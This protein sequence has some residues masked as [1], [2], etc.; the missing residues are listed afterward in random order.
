[1]DR[2]SPPPASRLV[3][4]DAARAFAALLVLVDH[5]CDPLS[6]T[7][8]RLSRDWFNPGVF[9]VILF[10]LVS[11][12]IIPVSL[13]RSGSLWR[14]WV[15]RVFRLYPLYLSCLVLLLVTWLL[16]LRIL[17]RELVD[18]APWSW[19]ANA[20][21]ATE[22]LRFQYADG[23]FWTLTYEMLFYIV[24]SLLFVLGLMRRTL[25][26]C[27]L[28]VL[29][30]V[31]RDVALP[32]LQHQPGL[33]ARSFWML[34]FFVGTLFHRLDAGHVSGRAFAG[35]I[36]TLG[37]SLC[38]TAWVNGRERMTTALGEIA[39]LACVSAWVAGYACFVVLLRTPARWIPR[40]LSRLGEVSYSIYLLQDHLMAPVVSFGLG[41]IGGA[42][43]T[44][45]TL[46]LSFVTYRWIEKPGIALGRGLVAWLSGSPERRPTGTQAEA[47]FAV[48]RKS[49]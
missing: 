36:T 46:G 10:F 30:L 8:Y 20:T 29:V 22:V 41:W 16:G 47:D 28:G 3:T 42:V 26:L 49:A 21:M 32:I 48:R 39:P 37:V 45:G 9:G 12:Y 5:L 31:L 7:F 33:H 38:A 34:T 4:L 35:L 17:P 24:C 40:P 14:F 44:A 6:P 13:E 2:S 1:M 18:R 19:L 27:W 25:I 11:G 23:I 15:S 43:A